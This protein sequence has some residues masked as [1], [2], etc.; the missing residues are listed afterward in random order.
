LSP[1]RRNLLWAVALVAALASLFLAH[2]RALFPPLEAWL[3]LAPVPV[4]AAL[5]DRSWVRTVSI[6]AS[7][8]LA[9]SVAAAFGVAILPAAGAALMIA[10]RAGRHR[11]AVRSGLAF[12]AA[13]AITTGM[14]PEL[15]HEISLPLL[16]GALAGSLLGIGAPEVPAQRGFDRWSPAVFWCLAA[17]AFWLFPSSERIS[18]GIMLAVIAGWLAPVSILATIASALLAASAFTG[19]LAIAALAI[20]FLWGR[21]AASLAEIRAE[22]GTSIAAALATCFGAGYT[23][24]GGGTVGAVTAIPIGWCLAQVDPTARALILLAAA[25]LSIGVAYWYMAGR[26]GPLDPQ[27]IVLDEHIGVLI[28]FA[29]VPWEWPWV[30]AAFVLFRLF[31]IW[32]PWPVRW[33]DRRVKNPAGV[34]LDDYAAGLMAAALLVA[35]HAHGCRVLCADLNG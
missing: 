19:E 28:A 6:T 4:I 5:L 8:V 31:D 13:C 10:D 11:D 3:A 34:M 33:F 26:E 17:A 9:M 25:A 30:A 32:K 2:R 15:K 20:A 23:P 35:A 27:E 22:H 21:S 1:S 12:A 18:G 14:L 29:V 7:V 24:R 16:V